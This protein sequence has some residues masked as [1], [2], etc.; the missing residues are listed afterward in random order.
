MSLELAALALAR[1]MWANIHGQVLFLL[2]L[3]PDLVF[4]DN[5]FIYCLSFSNL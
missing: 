5:E 1:D 4:M 2:K 3:D